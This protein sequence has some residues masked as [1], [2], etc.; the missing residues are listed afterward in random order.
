M[1]EA[2][3]A[4]LIGRSEFPGA[5]CV[6][7]DLAERIPLRKNRLIECAGLSEA[8]F[9]QWMA[10][11]RVRPFTISVPPLPPGVRLPTRGVLVFSKPRFEKAGGEAVVSAACSLLFFRIASTEGIDPPQTE[12]QKIAAH[13][14]RDYLPM[15]RVLR[16]LSVSPVQPPDRLVLLALV[17]FYANV[18]AEGEAR[19]KQKLFAVEDDAPVGHVCAY[20][21]AV[22]AERRSASAPA[23]VVASDAWPQVLLPR[24]R[25]LLR[26][27]LPARRLAVAPS[28]LRPS[29]LRLKT[30][31]RRLRFFLFDQKVKCLARAPRPR[32][33]LPGRRPPLAFV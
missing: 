4:V 7:A 31:A 17:H 28:H 10:P 15:L 1:Q 18:P 27:P 11:D 13:L 16:R 14:Q 9:A 29:R 2:A 19:L 23:C 3:Q 8:S 32:G 30:C 26:P 12:S 5:Y 6:H 22:A 21:S 20:C 24:R 25:V 33:R